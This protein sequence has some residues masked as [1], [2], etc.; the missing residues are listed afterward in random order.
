MGVTARGAVIG[1]DLVPERLERAW[2]NGFDVVTVERRDQ[3]VGAV[4]ALTQGRGP[5][6]V[7]DAVRMEAHRSPVGKVAHTM[8]SLPTRWPRS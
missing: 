2:R 8:T 7:I 3:V 6:A 5:D 4:R 1:I